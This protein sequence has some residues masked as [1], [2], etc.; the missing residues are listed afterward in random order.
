[1]AHHELEVT[2]HVTASANVKKGIKR[3]ESSWV[4]FYAMFNIFLTVPSFI[5]AVMPI[6]WILKIVLFITFFFSLS[7]LCLF[8][9]RFQNKLVGWK[10]R[11]ENTFKEI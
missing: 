11:V 1:M 3:G 10:T 5:V 4:F 9:T 7:Y 6:Y 8:N 2:A